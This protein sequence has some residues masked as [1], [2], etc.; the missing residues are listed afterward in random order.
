VKEPDEEQSVWRIEIPITPEM[1]R[2]TESSE[3]LRFLEETFAAPPLE[4]HR[5]CVWPPSDV[6]RDEIERRLRDGEEIEDILATGE[7]FDF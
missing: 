2:M 1:A 3:V 7:T 5:I 6:A 4:E